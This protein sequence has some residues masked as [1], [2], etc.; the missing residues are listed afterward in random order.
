M[1]WEKCDKRERERGE[2][3]RKNQKIKKPKIYAKR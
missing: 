1:L 2:C 3:R